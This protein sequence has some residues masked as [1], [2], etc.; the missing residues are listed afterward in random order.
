[1]NIVGSAKLAILKL[2]FLLLLLTGCS[3]VPQSSPVTL[4]EPALQQ[5]ATPGSTPPGDWTLRIERPETDQVRD[6]RLVLVR[7]SNASLRVFSPARWVDNIPDLL[8]ASIIRHLRDSQRLADVSASAPLANRVLRIDLRKFEAVD[9]AS[10]P[11]RTE[12][13]IDARLFDGASGDILSRRVFAHDQTIDQVEAADVAAGVGDALDRLV[14]E[15]ADWVVQAGAAVEPGG[16]TSST[17]D[18]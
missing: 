2:L 11:L 16:A 4:I 15:L 9:D 10:A 12:I 3:L 8:R 1:M 13:V 18:E 5:R 7:D 17:M 6:S 14:A